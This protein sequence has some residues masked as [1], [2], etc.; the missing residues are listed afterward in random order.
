TELAVR[1]EGM[2]LDDASLAPHRIPALFV[3]APVMLAGRLRGKPGGAIVVTGRT[4]SGQPWSQRIPVTEATGDATAAIWARA[5][6]RDLEDLYA[7][8]THRQGELEKE[9]VAVS[10]RHRVL[11]RFTAFLAVDRSEKVNPKG[12][13]KQVVQPVEMPRGWNAPAPVTRAGGSVSKTMM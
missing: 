7:V 1:A 4:P 6:I 10:L 9:I 2:S 11:S 12:D 13:P 8:Q 3:G 5:R